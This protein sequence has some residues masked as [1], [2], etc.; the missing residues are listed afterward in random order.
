MPKKTK[1]KKATKV[2]RLPNAPLVEV[3]FELRWRLHGEN[4]PFLSDPGILP[5]IKTFAERIADSGYTAVQ[6][7]GRV[8]E[9]IGAA[10]IARRYRKS[11]EQAFP[12]MQVGPGMFASN[13][14]PAY[15]WSRFRAQVLQGVEVLLDSYPLLPGYALTPQSLELRYI[16]F[17]DESVLDTAVFKEF[18]NQGTNMGIKPPP[19]L[20]DGTRFHPRLASRVIFNA[21][22]ILWP[23]S[24]FIVD[25]G[26]VVRD[27]QE[28]VR[29]ESKVLTT[30]D[31]VPAISTK[32]KYLANLQEWLEFAHGITSPFFKAFIAATLM[33]R[34][35]TAS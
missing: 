24:V 8:E 17:F 19:F 22:P 1:P 23:D 26:T 16:D 12:I 4:A 9:M 10:G 29:L 14:G 20:E 5:L 35:E 3:V 18:V 15:D 30:G 31:S 34:F 27:G 32:Q 7:L 2:D 25:F 21:K 11:A 13:D 28:A 33:R 6:E